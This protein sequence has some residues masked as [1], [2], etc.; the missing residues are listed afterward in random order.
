VAPW[1]VWSADFE[2]GP[3]VTGPATII[4]AAPDAAEAGEP[5]FVRVRGYPGLGSALA[6]DQPV[7]IAPGAAL[8][9]RFTVAIAD[10]RLSGDEA[11]ALAAGVVAQ[12]QGTSS[13]S[14]G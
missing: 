1:V 4:I 6:W 3:G 7:L 5:W 2:A 12:G 9:R 14:T 8:R 13:A 11:R 10:G